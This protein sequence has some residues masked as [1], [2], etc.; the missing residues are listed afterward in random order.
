MIPEFAPVGFSSLL[1]AI[2][3]GDGLPCLTAPAPCNSSPG[4]IHTPS[5]VSV[6]AKSNRGV[7]PIRILGRRGS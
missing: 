6:P 1:G 5:P 3:A 4:L 7:P 2:G